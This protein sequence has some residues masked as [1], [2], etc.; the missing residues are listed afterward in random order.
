M[1]VDEWIMTASTKVNHRPADVYEIVRNQWG[2]FSNANDTDAYFAIYSMTEMANYLWGA[3]PDKNREINTEHIM[4][5]T[6]TL[7]YLGLTIGSMTPGGDGS[8]VN[9]T[10]GVELGQWLEEASEQVMRAGRALEKVRDYVHGIVDDTPPPHMAGPTALTVASTPTLVV[11]PLVS[12]CRAVFLAL[13][14]DQLPSGALAQCLS[15][16]FPQRWG[17]MTRAKL[18][19]RLPDGIRPEPYANGKSR[20]VRE[21]FYLSADEMKPLP[22]PHFLAVVASAF[23][24]KAEDALP[25][26]WLH[27]KWIGHRINAKSVTI[28][29]FAELMRIHGVRPEWTKSGHFV[30]RAQLRAYIAGS[31]TG[32]EAGHNDTSGDEPAAS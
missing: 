32:G 10:Y 31:E 28:I 5:L 24:G 1:K 2:T 19:P 7:R 23:A 18:A 15:S 17:G 29:E 21:H 6:Q 30:R 12:D 9:W 27:D 13:G 26:G 25:V 22:E 11:T 16:M 14:V 4:Q 20:Y 8:D 3:L